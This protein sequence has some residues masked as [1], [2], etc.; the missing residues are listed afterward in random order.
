MC[1]LY[2]IL[3]IFKCSTFHLFLFVF[4]LCCFIEAMKD[5]TD[6]WTKFNDVKKLECW[7]ETERKSA[8][9]LGKYKRVSYCVFGFVNIT[10]L[11][12]VF[13]QKKRANS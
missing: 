13:I 7:T 5:L 9:L 1:I 8:S 10:V 12:F 11:V 4:S 6:Y 3:I 2:I